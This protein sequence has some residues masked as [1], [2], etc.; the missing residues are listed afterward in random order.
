MQAARSL[1]LAAV[2]FLGAAMVHADFPPAA[3]LPGQ[4]EVPDPLMS[5]DG[6]RITTKEDWTTK[7]RP[8][9]KELF[10]HYMYGYFPPPPDNLAF[11][12][13]R[14]DP[15]ALGGKATLKEITIS[16]G[17]PGTPKIHLLL[18]VPNKRQGRA[19]VFVGMNFRGNHCVLNDPAIR[20]PEAWMRGNDPTVKNNKATDAGRGTEVDV[21]A[22]EQTIDRGYAVATFYCGDVDPDRADVRQGIQPHLSKPG[23]KPGPHDWGTIAAWAWGIQRVVDYLVQDADIDA[24]RIIVV[25]HSRLGKTALLAGAFDERIALAIP[26]Q[27]GCGGTAPNRS[28]N[29]KAETV[30]RINT[31]F[32]HWFNGAFK[33]F[34]DQVDRL[35][36]DQ[37]C[38]IALMVPR[39]VLLS[40]AVEDQWANPDGQFDMLKAAEPVYRLL[41]AGGLETKT[42]PEVG[43]LSG[44]TLGY[45]IRAGK[46]SMTREDWRIFVDFAERHLKRSGASK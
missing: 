9:L 25:G 46:H 30:K 43:K 42:M 38:L 24:S 23:T 29:P 15:K 12:V 14:T 40:N 19:P 2:L 18:V 1:P 4:P 39:P 44:G 17:P 20:L 31:S 26:H 6:K 3:K 10:Q 28:R 41:G 27:A 36:F 37:H 33:E 16:F 32:P 45:Y 7:R 34:N 8:E 11:K 21:W 35:P 5:F 22:I 13:E